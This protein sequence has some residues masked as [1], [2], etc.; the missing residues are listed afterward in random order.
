MVIV[1]H[2]QIADSEPDVHELC[3]PVRSSFWRRRYRLSFTKGLFSPFMMSATWQQLTYFEQSDDYA[4]F[5]IPG[6]GKYYLDAWIDDDWMSN[7]AATALGPSQPE[8]FRPDELTGD[9]LAT[10]DVFTGA[11]SERLLSALAPSSL[12]RLSSTN[13]DAFQSSQRLQST[14]STKKE[15]ASTAMDL[16]A[17]PS[18]QS[19]ESSAQSELIDIEERM[20]RELRFLGAFPTDIATPFSAR[21]RGGE[22]DWSNRR[23]DEITAALRDCQW[24]LNDQIT[25]NESRK[26]RLVERVKD[27]MARQEFE[28]LRDTLEKQIEAGWQKRQKS[29][30]KK[31]NALRGAAAAAAAAAAAS[32]GRNHPDHSADGGRTPFPEPLLASLE[33]RQMLVEGFKPMFD[34]DPARFGG[35]PPCSIHGDDL[36]EGAIPP[37]EDPANAEGWKESGL[38]CQPDT[39]KIPAVMIE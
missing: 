21:G 5:V 27:R 24:R 12:S 37:I 13:D 10:E 3:R 36:E 38:H 7:A 1:Y 20:R 9:K 29:I 8:C 16:D 22:L 17:C 6:L 25:V 28:A 14:P 11:L 30:K 19:A 2:K 32:A 39:A 23:D 26:S 18:S 15:D 31:P 35:I 4:P 33:R 34:S